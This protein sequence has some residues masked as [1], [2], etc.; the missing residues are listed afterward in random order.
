M[1]NFFSDQRGGHGPSGP[2]VNTPLASNE[3]TLYTV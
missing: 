2:M 1:R 3:V